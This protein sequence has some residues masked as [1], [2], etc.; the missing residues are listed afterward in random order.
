MDARAQLMELK[1]TWSP[2]PELMR[3]RPRELRLTAA[4]KILRLMSGLFI[5]GAIAAGVIMYVDASRDLEHRRLLNVQGRDTQGRV[6]RQWKSGGEQPAFWCEYVYEVDGRELSGR[7]EVGRSGW[8]GIV[9]GAT[10]PVRYLPSDPAVHLVSGLEGKPMP[11]W[12]P[13][14]AA[15]ALAAPG[16]LIGLPLA[17]ERRLL[18]DGRPAPAVITHLRKTKDGSVAH[19]SF[20]ELDG[21]VV[22][23]RTGPRRRGVPE[24][25]TVLC[26]LYEPDHASRN[27]AYPLKFYRVA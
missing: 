5:F 11:L 2:P 19:Y 7:V 20:A 10:L 13:F 6:V 27:K 25:G 24:P 9:R 26:V 18:A 3:E 23:G 17:S 12:L 16:W 14:L 22:N 4:G 15:A 8:N 1:S 21:P